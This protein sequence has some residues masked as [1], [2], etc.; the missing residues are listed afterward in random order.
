[1]QSDVRELAKRESACC[2]F[3]SFD[4][5]READG[6][7]LTI[8]APPQAEADFASLIGH[9]LPPRATH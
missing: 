7:R 1:M 6:L 2:A 8:S 3:L 9:L 4:L 5:Q